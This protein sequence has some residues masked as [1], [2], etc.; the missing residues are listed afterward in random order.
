VEGFKQGRGLGYASAIAMV[1]LAI[2]LVLYLIQR[3]F[4]DTPSDD[5]RGSGLRGL[6]HRFLHREQATGA[7]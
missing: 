4:T 5:P 1:L 3:Q 6:V 7:T 2:I